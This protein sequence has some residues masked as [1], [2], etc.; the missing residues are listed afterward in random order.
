MKLELS[1]VRAVKYFNPAPHL[2]Q[3]LW[4]PRW[5]LSPFG[6]EGINSSR[7][8]GRPAHPPHHRPWLLEMGVWEKGK[9]IS[10]CLDYHQTE[11]YPLYSTSQSYHPQ[12][13]YPAPGLLGHTLPPSTP[14]EPLAPPAYLN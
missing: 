12:C 6:G 5:P 9:F 14:W 8:P 13:R 2:L 11:L 1:K 3:Q 7:V 10:F 4:F